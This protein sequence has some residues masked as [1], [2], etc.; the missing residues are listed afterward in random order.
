[1]TLAL[2]SIIL[3]SGCSKEKK[4]AKLINDYYFKTLDD[5]DSYKPVETT[6]DS[7]FNVPM[8]NSEIVKGC[9]GA[10]HHIASA[11]INYNIYKLYNEKFYLY[12]SYSS[13]Y[14]YF[15]M[16]KANDSCK[17]Y[18]DSI[19]CNY[20][21]FMI[22]YKNI[23]N[24][25]KSIDKKKFDCWKVKHS[26]RTNIQGSGIELESETFYIDKKCQEI[27]FVETEMTDEQFL[28]AIIEKGGFDN[29][30]DGDY[31]IWLESISKLFG[32]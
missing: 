32:D 17:M 5:F 25:I 7:A 31:N 2:C 22:A 30:Y 13:D 16:V 28:S 1:M 9:Q 20:K 3:L 6:I 10:Y 21:N 15:Q 23:H 11:L 8:L 27:L 26:Y 19:K 4:V 12:N 14:A 29:Y 18:M 24:I